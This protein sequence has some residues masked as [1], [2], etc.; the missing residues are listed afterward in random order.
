MVTATLD[1]EQFAV[2]ALIRKLKKID[3]NGAHEG[4]VDLADFID[5]ADHNHIDIAFLDIDLGCSLN[6]LDLIRHLYEKYG[7]MNIIIY[8]GHP[9]PEYKVTALDNSVCGYI[10]K[11]VSDEEL[12]TAIAHVRCPIKELNIQCFGYF[13]V[14]YG[15][16]PV[17]FE[18]K[19]SKEVL[20]YLIDKRGAVVS[21]EEL[22]YLVFG[23][24]DDKEEKRTYIRNIIYDIR[25]T[26]GKYG[27]PKE[28]IINLKSAYSIDLSMLRCDLYDYINGKNVPAVKL[29]QYME[30]YS[31]TS[32]VKNALFGGKE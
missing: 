31:W 18:R 10:V 6:G 9:D 5:Y 21:E 8:T 4:F 13:E 7:D 26:L 19:D 20:A 25:K 11:P 2:N 17:R 32:G 12:R 16:A 28:I 30:Q 24:D 23:E 27:V 29:K 1:D 14:F 15:T 3:P 22:R